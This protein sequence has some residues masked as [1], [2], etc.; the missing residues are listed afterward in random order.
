LIID[1]TIA[2]VS[3]I[4]KYSQLNHPIGLLD[5]NIPPQISGIALAQTLRTNFSVKGITGSLRFASGNPNLSNYGQGD[6][7]HNVSFG[8]V[9]FKSGNGT[10]QGIYVYI[11]MYIHVYIYIHMYMHIYVYICIYICICI[12][13]YIYM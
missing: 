6:R 12:Y 2:M 8:I 7:Q 9:N 4:I 11:C 1:A 5:F 13:M 3:A 10:L